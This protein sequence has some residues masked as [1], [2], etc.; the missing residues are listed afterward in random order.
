MESQTVFT[1]GEVATLLGCGRD[2]LLYAVRSQGCPNAS[3][4]HGRH[5]IWT[6]EDLE[7]AREFFRTRRSRRATR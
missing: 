4:K 2:T 6:V 5:R 1:S 7:K 3:G